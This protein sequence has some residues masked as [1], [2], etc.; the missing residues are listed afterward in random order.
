LFGFGK[1]VSKLGSEN[2]E[3]FVSLKIFKEAPQYFGIKMTN[4]WF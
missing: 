4:K 3:E 1:R 2:K